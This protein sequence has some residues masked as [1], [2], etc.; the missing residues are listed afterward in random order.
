MKAKQEKSFLIGS[1]IVFPG[2][3]IL[4]YIFELISGR[5]KNKSLMIINFFVPS[6]F[7]LISALLI[8]LIYRKWR[9]GIKSKTISYLVLCF[10]I[11][12]QSIKYIIKSS[13]LGQ[14]SME[15]IKG[16]FYIDPI[17]NTSGSWVASRLGIKNMF[18]W[19]IVMNIIMLPLIIQAYRF[20]TYKKEKSF[21]MDIFFLLILSGAACSLIDKMFFGGSLDYLSM[22]PLFVADLKDFYLT[23]SICCLVIEIFFNS[24]ESLDNS[25]D[26]EMIIIKEFVN[27]NIKDIRRL[28]KLFEGIIEN[29]KR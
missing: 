7:L 10:I 1:M 17:V 11:I 26:E 22:S 24:K 20:Y 6:I 21:W 25:F 27:Y 19:A 2:V 28:P 14:N 9:E 4:Y 29:F 13:D 8:F 18:F 15:V 16:W 12:D 5:L 23:F 3:W